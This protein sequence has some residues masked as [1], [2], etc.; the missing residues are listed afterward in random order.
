M[1]N[2]VLHPK[3]PFWQYQRLPG[4]N[5]TLLKTALWSPFQAEYERLHGDD[6][7]A[8]D[9]ALFRAI[10]ADLLEGAE[11]FT[12]EFAVCDVVRN[13]KHQAFKDWCAANR[14]KTA[15]TTKQWDKA[16]SIRAAL[17]RQG[18]REMLGRPGDFGHGDGEVT[19]TWHDDEFDLSC[20]I[21]IDWLTK[22]RAWAVDIKNCGELTD[23]DSLSKH[24]CG[25]LYD[26]QAAHYLRGLA[27]LGF[28]E[29]GWA[30]LWISGSPPYDA[31]VLPVSQ[32]FIEYGMARRA[33]AMRRWA[34]AVKSGYYPRALRDELESGAELDVPG[35]IG[36]GLD[37]EA[38]REFN[39]A[40]E[41]A[42]Y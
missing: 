5:S 1:S 22:D 12:A 38:M 35:Y 29:T 8:G 7:D 28:T 31:V 33:K 25:S 15:L 37:R 41:Q 16:L 40:I 17:E 30:H 42:A 2:P 11:A 27:E 18:V 34:D 39:A 21:R 3:M 20:K 23:L 13:A 32:R 10:H 9:R 24:A 4:T 26:I 6:G 36:R 14:D 19:V